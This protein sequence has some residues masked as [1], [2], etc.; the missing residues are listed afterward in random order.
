MIVV[1]SREK[2]M[3]WLETPTYHGVFP[4]YKYVFKSGIAA[5]ARYHGRKDL[6]GSSAST[7]IRRLLEMGVERER[8]NRWEGFVLRFSSEGFV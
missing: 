4:D 5:R 2:W 8:S 1:V 7:T 3:H 6:W